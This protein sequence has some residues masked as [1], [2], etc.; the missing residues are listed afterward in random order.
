MEPYN[1]CFLP[2]ELFSPLL[3]CFLPFE[4]F[5]VVVKDL[6]IGTDGRRLFT[7]KKELEGR[8]LTALCVMNDKVDFN[9]TKENRI[10]IQYICVALD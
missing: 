9:I 2:F 7:T 1:K 5:F 3:L 10:R 8:M 6:I 4:L